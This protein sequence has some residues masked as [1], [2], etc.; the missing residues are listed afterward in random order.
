M[1][2]LSLVQINNNVIVS[3]LSGGTLPETV[4][5]YL[6]RKYKAQHFGPPINI[7]A[8][9][10]ITVHL[11][12]KDVKLQELSSQTARKTFTTKS[13]VKT[14]PT[15]QSDDKESRLKHLM[16]RP[17]LFSGHPDAWKNTVEA[18][19]LRRAIE[20]DSA[21]TR[22]VQAS[23]DTESSE[24]EL[25]PSQV[26]KLSTPSETDSYDDDESSQE[27][28]IKPSSTKILFEKPKDKVI[29]L[30]LTSRQLATLNKEL[31]KTREQ[32]KTYY[33]NPVDDYQVGDRVIYNNMNYVVTKFDGKKTI[34]ISR[35]N[36]LGEPVIPRNTVRAVLNNYSSSDKPKNWL[37]VGEEH[38]AAL[39]RYVVRRGILRFDNG[40]RINSARSLRV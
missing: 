8:V 21:K 33:G 7:C 26:N 10:F 19:T 40:P 14:T 37:W 9:P 13:P 22:K 32:K 6:S 20:D 35:V 12:Y 30:P 2:N 25:Y 16:T 18:V 3:H 29:E 31:S 36:M 34:E 4:V 24:E 15:E 39:D 23:S 5:E 38:T 17:G 1:Q 27:E 28:F 11:L